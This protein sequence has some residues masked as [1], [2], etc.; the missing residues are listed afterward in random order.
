VDKKKV[1]FFWLRKWRKKNGTG[2]SAT[3]TCLRRKNLNQSP[4]GRREERKK[5]SLGKKETEPSPIHNIPFQ[6]GTI[7]FYGK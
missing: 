2:Q 6:H 1:S 7:A 4:G 3:W 5:K